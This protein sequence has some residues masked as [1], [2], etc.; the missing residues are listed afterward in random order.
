MAKEIGDLSL[1][2]TQV[3]KSVFVFS[4]RGGYKK[5]QK[6]EGEERGNFSQVIAEPS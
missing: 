4:W 2:T 5:C 6:K 1:K 3:G